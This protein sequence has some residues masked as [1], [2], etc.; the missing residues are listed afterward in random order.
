M[1]DLFRGEL[2]RLTAEDPE[3]RAKVEAHWQRDSEYHRM[4]DTDPAQPLSEK[5]LKERLEKRLEDDP[6]PDGHFFSV[7]TLAEDKLIG[8]FGMWADLVHGEAWVGIGI[9]ERE[10]WGRG[11]GTDAMRLCLQYAF[12]ELNVHRVS[13]GLLDYNPRALRSYEKAGFRLE[14]RTRGDVLREGKR[15]DSLWMGILR[16]EWLA[17]QTGEKP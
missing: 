17:M 14:G 3:V 15:G 12:I 13:L 4:L 11:Y 6:K 5:K 16:D 8:F 1:R 9:G 2:V 7:R 10:F